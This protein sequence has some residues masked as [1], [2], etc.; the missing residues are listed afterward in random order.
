MEEEKE[1]TQIPKKRVT[2]ADSNDSDD[3]DNSE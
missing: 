2:F 3:S 1:E